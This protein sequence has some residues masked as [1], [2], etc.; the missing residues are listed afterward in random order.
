MKALSIRQPWVFHILNSGKDIENRCWPT[1]VRGRVL[2]HAAKGMTRDDY[3]NG[4]DPLWA[5]QGRVIELPP[6]NLLARGGIV[7][8]VEIVDCVTTS[9]SP[10]FNGQFGFVLRDPQPL[11]FVPMKGRLGFFEVDE[12]LLK[13]HG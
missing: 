13:S 12:S 8:S 10:W 9:D 3:D 6:H 1:K 11:P 7:G 5:S 4:Y 2:I